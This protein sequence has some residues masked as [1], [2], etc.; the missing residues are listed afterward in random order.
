VRQD[1]LAAV[2]NQHAAA[3]SGRLATLRACGAVVYGYATC[4]RQVAEHRI[5]AAQYLKDAIGGLTG[6]ACCDDADPGALA[7]D[8][9]RMSAISDVQVT[10]RICVVLAGAGIGDCQC[11]SASLQLD[12]AI[13]TALVR[14][15]NRM[16]QTVAGVKVIDGRIRR[17]TE[18]ARRMRRTAVQEQKHND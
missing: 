16:A 14:Q 6:E 9:H 17:G 8:R 12:G 5:G 11:V 4:D 18:A 13:L 3:L 7:L 15:V 2:L 1:N 10:I